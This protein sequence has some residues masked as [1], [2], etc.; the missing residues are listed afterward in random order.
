MRSEVSAGLIGEIYRQLLQPSF[1]TDELD[2][3][4]TILEG[5]AEGG[6]YDAWGACALDGQTPVGCVLGY[7]FNCSHVLLIGY[8]TV[9]PGRRSRGIG[10]LLMDHVQQKWYEKDD[11]ALVLAEV[12]DPR[13]H[14]VADGID[15]KRRAAFYGRRGAQV[16]VGPY[17]QPRVDSTAERVQNL[18]LTVLSGNRDAITPENSVRTAML[19][20]FLIE[21]FQQSG[22]G[23]DWPQAND[24]QGKRLLAWYRDRESVQLH[25]IGD[26]A[27]IQIPQISG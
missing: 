7:P 4:D 15:P 23:S 19:V 16:V 13:H 22:E 24:E 21:Y 18:F 8:V 20:D 26:Y 17:F 5:L 6:S 1:E 2:S 10:G 27:Q 9:K 14:P 3:L 12:E 25:P 11:L